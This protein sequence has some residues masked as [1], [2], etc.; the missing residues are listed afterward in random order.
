MFKPFSFESLFIVTHRNYDFDLSNGGFWVFTNCDV[1]DD[2]FYG[3][4]KR[5]L[6]YIIVLYYF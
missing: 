5:L 4:E 3:A 2:T 6:H 1:G